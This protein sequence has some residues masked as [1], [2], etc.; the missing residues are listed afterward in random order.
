M[1]YIN[2]D[3]DFYYLEV[4]LDTYVEVKVNEQMMLMLGDACQARQSQMP[5]RW[6]DVAREVSVNLTNWGVVD[7][8]VKKGMRRFSDELM[9]P[10]P[11][12]I[13][14]YCLRACVN[15]LISAELSRR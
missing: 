9:R 5:G 15:D 6:Q 7:D 10:N 2:V 13:F 11:E 4:D 14:R 1:F 8:E 12:A 3:L